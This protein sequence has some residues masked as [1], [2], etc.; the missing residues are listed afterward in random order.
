MALPQFEV[1]QCQPPHPHAGKWTF[2]V[3]GQESLYYCPRQ[4]AAERV[5]KRLQDPGALRSRESVGRQAARSAFLGQAVVAEAPR[6]EVVPLPSGRCGYRLDGGELVE[7]ASKAE[8]MVC[9]DTAAFMTRGKLGR[10]AEAK[11]QLEAERGCACEIAVENGKIVAIDE[12]G[13]RCACDVPARGPIAF[14]SA[15]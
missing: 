10:L 11:A 3:D 2:R 13:H 4:D 5:V 14:K 7:C 9:A 6:V 12:H 8:V 1:Y 15:E